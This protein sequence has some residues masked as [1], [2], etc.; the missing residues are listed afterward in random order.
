MTSVFNSQ[1][2]ERHPN[3]A[4]RQS[5][6]ILLDDCEA[7]PA[8]N[9]E[10]IDMEKVLNHLNYGYFEFDPTDET[11]NIMGAVRHRDKKV[12]LNSSL[13]PQEKNFALAHEIGHIILHRDSDKIDFLKHTP[14]E[15][16]IEEIEANVFAY[17]LLMPSQHFGSNL[18]KYNHNYK[19]LA[20]FYCVTKN[21]IKKRAY[22]ENK[23]RKQINTLT[24]N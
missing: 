11:S 17:E 21:K 7:T 13:S 2:R 18:K 3:L 4:I 1:K 6:N 15:F 24:A 19:L 12:F 16:C 20:D 9:D 14:D 5:A 10:S 23:L 22:Y 8:S